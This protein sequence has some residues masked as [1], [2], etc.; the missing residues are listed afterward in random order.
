MQDRGKRAAVR[1]SHSEGKTYYRIRGSP[2]NVIYTIGIEIE[3]R[4][5]RP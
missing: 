1:K 3:A 4:R 5:L 2:E